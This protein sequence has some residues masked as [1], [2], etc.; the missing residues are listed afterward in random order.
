MD[1]VALLAPKE[2]SGIGGVAPRV[3]G[4]QQPAKAVPSTSMGSQQVAG[5]SMPAVTS[6]APPK[7]PPQQASNF[8]GSAVPLAATNTAPSMTSPQQAAAFGGF[9]V[10]SAAMRTTPS[11]TPPQQASTFGGFSVPLTA[12]NRAPTTTPTNLYIGETTS[13]LAAL[14]Q[15]QM[16][17]PRV[18]PR[19]AKRVRTPV[20]RQPAPPVAYVEESTADLAALLAGAARAPRASEPIE[21]VAEACETSEGQGATRSDPRQESPGTSTG[22]AAAE[23]TATAGSGLRPSALE[24]RVT[25]DYFADVIQF[26]DRCRQAAHPHLLHQLNA[27]RRLLTAGRRRASLSSRQCR[28][29]FNDAL[30]RMPSRAQWHWLFVFMQK[31]LLLMFAFVCFFLALMEVIWKLGP[32]PEIF[33]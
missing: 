28:L 5:F 4:Q 9:A 18:E 14:L 27:F 12:T 24:R 33:E 21:P 7:T 1:L 11:T 15:P 3:H 17:Q 16:S 31:V 22:S 25:E 30:C 2:A 8:G 29:Y 26:L 10:P 13:E 19:P 20:R 23:G 6:L 32:E